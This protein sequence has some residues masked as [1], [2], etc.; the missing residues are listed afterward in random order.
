MPQC[1]GAAQMSK[2]PRKIVIEILSNDDTPNGPVLALLE[3]CRWLKCGYGNSTAQNDTTEITMRT[4][5]GERVDLQHCAVCEQIQ[6][7]VVDICF[8]CVK[9]EAM[10][11]M[12]YADVIVDH[13]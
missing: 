9:R 10:Q 1:E 12:G 5:Y 4:K 2:P 3:A 11:A 7:V 8:G 13:S 6:P